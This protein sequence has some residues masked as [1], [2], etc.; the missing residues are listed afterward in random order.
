MPTI[1]FELFGIFFEWD[2]DKEKL[3]LQQRNISFEECCSVFYDDYN[4]T[5]VDG[6][7]EDDEQRYITIGL[8]NRARLLSVAWT[9]RGKNIRLITAVKAEKYHERQYNANKY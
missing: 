8:S 6:R 1:E 9:Q 3:L 2:T 5:I 7:F 4:H